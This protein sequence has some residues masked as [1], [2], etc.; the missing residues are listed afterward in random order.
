MKIWKKVVIIFLLLAVILI[1][2]FLLYTN[3]FYRADISVDDILD[4]NSIDVY[5]D[6]DIIV[7][8]SN[9]K[10]DSEKGLIFYPGGKV[11]Y[12]SYIPLLNSL[13]E[14]GVTTV[15][16]KMPLNLA[17]FNQDAAEEV[18]EILPNISNW[19]IGGHSLGAAMASRYVDDASKDIKGLILLAAYPEENKSLPTISIYGS[20]DKV[21][22]QEQ[23]E[24]DYE[25]LEIDGGN[26]AYFG[27]YG[28]QDGDGKATISREEQQNITIKAIMHFIQTN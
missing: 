19:Y 8:N 12:T 16:V 25:V 18:Y 10:N 4:S 9:I 15:L 27:N 2:G 22:T 11:E 13:S 20:Q 5:E 14:E 6:K 17:V 3:D 26:H 24:G 28:D 21:L 7:F 23:I 1:S